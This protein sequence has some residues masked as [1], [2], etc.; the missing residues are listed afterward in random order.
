MVKVESAPTTEL[1]REPD[2]S[3][4]PIGPS[5]N[6]DPLYAQNIALTARQHADNIFKI[7]NERN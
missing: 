2:N 1:V 4:N 6:R 7:W 5:V 3:K